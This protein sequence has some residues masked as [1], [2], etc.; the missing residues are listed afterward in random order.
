[1]QD[2][3]GVVAM[4]VVLGAVDPVAVAELGR[5]AVDA[6]VPVVA[7][8]VLERIERDL[9]VDL[10]VAG[11]GKHQ[12]DGRPVPAKQDEIDAAGRRER[13]GRNRAAAGH[14]QRAV[15]VA[16]LDRLEPLAFRLCQA[17]RFNE[18]SRKGQMTA[19]MT[20]R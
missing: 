13:A 5:K 9:G 4:A 12:P 20:W 6:D 18:S 17:Y 10:A 11:L 3:P 16:V 1:M 14:D 8:L 15:A 2:E 19:G 7:R